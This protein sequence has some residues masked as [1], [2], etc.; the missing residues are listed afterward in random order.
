MHVTVRGKIMTITWV[1]D[2]EMVLKT[3]NELEG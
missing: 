2:V 1:L 3:V